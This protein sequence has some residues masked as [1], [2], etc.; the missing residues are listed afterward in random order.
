MTSTASLRRLLRLPCALICALALHAG[1]ARAV[2]AL[3]CS[4]SVSTTSVSFGSLNPLSAS[5]S[6]STGSVK[7]DCGGV[8]GLLIPY[9]IDLG[10]GL[11]GS[12]AA[13]RLTSGANLLNYNLYVDSNRLAVW[14]DGSAGTQSV[15][16]SFTLDVL[17]SAPTQTQ[18]VYGRVPGSQTSTVPGSYTDTIGVTLTYF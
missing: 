10:P 2:C 8:A 3:V 15:N 9:R 16:G 12:Y 17:G 5:A 7:V 6:D 1:D 18:W 13:R 14:G 11:T 4:C